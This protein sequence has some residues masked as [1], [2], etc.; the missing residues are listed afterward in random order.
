[1]S[2]FK[3]IILLSVFGVAMAY[4][5]AAV[6]VYLRELYYPN[7]FRFPMEIISGQIAAT[8]IGREATTLLMLWAIAQLSGRN[9]KERFSYFCFSF[10]LWDLFYYIWLKVLINW[11]SAWLEWDILFLIPA[12]WI[13][14]WLAPALVSFA[15]ISASL[16]VL[17]YP[18]RFLKS[19][20]SHTEWFLVLGGAAIILVSF[21]YQTFAVLNG[22]IPDYYPWWIFL[23][24]FIL[25]L[26]TFTRRI[27]RVQPNDN[28][29]TQYQNIK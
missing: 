2:L 11:P 17:L 3:K 18:H 10:G 27:I 24:G 1:M 7:G 26:G 23:S 28:I 20:L 21:F 4:L 19:I 8:E 5:E 25:G 9:F 16:L 12:P 6:V 15:L 22:S 29:K 14:P 13:A